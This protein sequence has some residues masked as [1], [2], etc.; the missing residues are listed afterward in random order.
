[1]SN[2]CAGLLVEWSTV[3]DGLLAE[4][5]GLLIKGSTK[6]LMVER[7]SD[8]LLVEGPPNESV[9]VELSLSEDDVSRAGTVTA[10]GF[11][12]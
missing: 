1:M 10:L 12:G 7:S 2:G 6:E 4:G 11:R 9:S 5:T 3:P 8:R